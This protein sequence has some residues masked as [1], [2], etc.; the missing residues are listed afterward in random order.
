MTDNPLHAKHY[1]DQASFVRAAVT[2]SN[3]IAEHTYCLRVSAA[4]IA[5][6]VCP[7]QFMMVRIDGHNDPL[8][9]RAFAMYQVLGDDPASREELEFAF[10]AKGKMTTRLAQLSPGAK[11]EIWGPLGCGFNADPCD[12]L[13]MAAGGIGQTPFLALGREALGRQKFGSRANGYA[14]RVTLVYGVRNEAMI[15]GESEFTDAGIELDI[16]TDDGSRGYHG[17]V[18]DR[19]NELLA[20]LATEQT[21]GQ[22]T[23]VVCCGPEPMMQRTAEVCHATGTACS[24]SLETPMAC[25]IGICFSCVAKVKLSDGSWDYKRTCVDGPVFDSQ[26]IVW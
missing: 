2:K 26:Q 20:K 16:C 11:L 14:K 3:R 1:A 21:S 23:R 15:A 7:G 24:V 4:E 8:I 22:T 6:T 17:L 9:G 12:H 5:K 19:L 25:G 10:I 18:P 13:I